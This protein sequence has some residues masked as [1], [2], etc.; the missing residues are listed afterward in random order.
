VVH[1]F[2][3]HAAATDAQLEQRAR[4]AATLLYDSQHRRCKPAWLQ[5]RPP[6]IGFT[7]PLQVL[8]TPLSHSCSSRHC[9]APLLRDSICGW[10]PCDRLVGPRVSETNFKL[11]NAAN[12][13]EGWF[14][15]R[16]RS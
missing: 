16:Q 8:L 7:L 15:E 12:A 9:L 3:S 14:F 4:S 1:C 11:G 10:Y 13:N 2:S 5:E 6:L